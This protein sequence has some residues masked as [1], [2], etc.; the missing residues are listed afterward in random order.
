MLTISP[1]SQTFFRKSPRLQQNRRLEKTPAKDTVEIS[2]K[3]SP[4]KSLLSRVK[5]IPSKIWSQ[6]GLIPNPELKNY[7]Y[8]I[9]KFSE[10][11]KRDFVK[12]YCEM[13]GFPDLKKVSEKIDNE[14]V[15][16]I[17]KMTEANGAKA[18]FTAYGQNCSV[19]RQRALPG[20]DCDG[21]FIVL[22]RPQN[23]ELN[24][25]SFGFAMNQRIVDSTGMHFPEVFSMEEMMSAIKDAEELFWKNG[26]WKKDSIYQQN[27][28]YDGKSFIKAAEFNIDLANL[29]KN[30]FQKD[31]ICHASL[32]VEELRAG[33]ALINNI[34]ENTLK[35]IKNSILY[36]YSNIVRTEGL[37]NK[38]KPKLENR[39]RLCKDFANMNDEEKFQTCKNL[40]ASSIGIESKDQHGCYEEFDMGDIIELYRKIS[41]WMD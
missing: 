21:F 12:S 28:T 6:E 37:K 3:Q 34:D 13:T 17:L 39:I 30:N 32:F 25:A 9:E 7:L 20:S 38:F 35:F 29:A 22:D 4:A 40:F 2:F 33:K 41:S 10:F 1:F 8:E 23:S 31:M 19:G 36:K 11:E 26:M 24:R 16:N 14:I 18:L 27:L 15:S 5:Y